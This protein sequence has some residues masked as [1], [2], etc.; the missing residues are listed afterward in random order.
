MDNRLQFNVGL[1]AVRIQNRFADRGAIGNALSFD[2]TQP[3]RDSESPFGGFTTWTQ[4]DGNPNVI[5]TSNPVALL[6]LKEDKSTVNRYIA[7]FQ[8]DYRFDFLPALRANLNLAYDNSSSEG[9]IFIPEFASFKF[10]DGGEDKFYT[11]DRRNELAEFYL[12]YKRDFGANGLDVL[13]GYSWQHFFQ[14]NFVEST[15]IDGSKILEAPNRDPREYFLLSLYGRINYNLQDKYLFTFTLRR[16]GTSRFAPENRYGL[17]PAAAAAIKLVN[18]DTAKGLSKLKLRLGWGLTGQQDIGDQTK[19]F[20]AYLPQYQSSL[21]NAQYQFGDEFVTTIR[22]NG[23]DANIKWEETTTY[24]LGIDYGFLQDRIYGSLDIYQRK[25]KDLL[26]F[27]PVPAGTNLTNFLTTNVGDLENKGIELA[28]NTSAIETEDMRWD[29]GFN[30]AY[31]ENEI[32]RL[33][34]SDDPSYQGVLVGGISGGV[35]SNIQIHSVG[36]PASSFFVF[37][38]VYDA[39]GV[40][41]EGL[42]VDRNGDGVINNGDQ[43]RSQKPAADYSIGF[44]TRFEY[45]KFDFSFAGRSSI[46]NY[47]YNNVWSSQAFYDRL[48]NSAGFTQNVHA[49]TAAIDFATPQFFSDFFVRNASFLRVD[50]IT[51]GYNMDNFIGDFARAYITI[52]NPV[53]FTNYEGIDPETDNGIDNNIYPRPRTFVFGISVDF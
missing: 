19:D 25:T 45:K 52:Q 1:K 21:E 17:F 13:A 48:F 27:V 3:V 26:N 44:T 20:Y 18:D 49:E 53:V 11:D 47:I 35:G 36:F 50:H 30:I 16:D 40:P 33:I 43:Y 10:T 34:A 24:N 7:N 8:A 23:Y 22:P 4:A 37:E 41:V 14:E 39:G 32:T 2:P 46:G 42:Y 29:V 31:N 5:A 12:N 51:L 28:I 9:T 6:E 38:Q 15:N